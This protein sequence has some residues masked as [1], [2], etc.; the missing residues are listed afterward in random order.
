MTTYPWMAVIAS[1][2]AISCAVH[3]PVRNPPPPV[4]VPD[5]YQ[6]SGATGALPERWWQAFGDR[7]LDQLVELALKGNLQLQGSWARIAQARA[8]ARQAGAGRWPQVNASA[9]ASRGSNRLNFGDQPPIE[10]TQN[11]FVA[12]VE[13]TYEV[14]LWQ[15]VGSQAKAAVRDL[16]A[17]RYDLEAMAISLAAEIS[18]AWFDGLAQ[19]EL[20]DLLTV[21]LETNST[22]VELV[23]MRFEQGLG[24][25]AADVFQARQQVVGTRAQLSLIEAREQTAAYR[26]AV[27]VGRAP[28][29]LAVAEHSELPE[30]PDLPGAGVPADLLL[31]RPDVRAMGRRVEAADWRL[32]AAVA[33]RLPRLSLAG[34]VS[35]QDNS[36]ANFIA[37]PLYNLAANLL[38]PLFDGGLRAAAA[39]RSRAVVAE[40]AASYGQILLQAL[41]E[42]E[43]ALVL[44]KAQLA[45]IEDLKQQVEISVETLAETRNRYREGITDFLPVITALRSLQAA[46]QSLL[47]ARRQ[48]LSYRVQLCRALGG[49]WT[50]ELEQGQS[51]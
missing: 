38:A 33:E 17:S 22:F 42:V 14:D 25:S 37:T 10:F 49:T 11:Q 28:G 4:P 1:V 6:S 39:D 15:R 27:L 13:A 21:Q 3:K 19:R 45:H 29:A 32:A 7:Q 31:R 8:A 16:E 36:L 30:L 24:A 12:S 35:L 2:G 51:S 5:A 40:L 26:L 41:F 43:T 23:T 20:R 46:E 18:E 34:S 50:G 9:R 44:E 47:S 48:L